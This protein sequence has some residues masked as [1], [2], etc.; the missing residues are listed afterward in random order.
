[1]PY[2]IL[3]NIFFGILSHIFSRSY[4]K[5]ER[6]PGFSYVWPGFR[7]SLQILSTAIIARFQG[8]I[9]ALMQAQT[10]SLT[11]FGTIILRY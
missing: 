3:R 11:L 5:A 1:M 2:R 8:F 10:L 6:W 9:V 7:R 4:T